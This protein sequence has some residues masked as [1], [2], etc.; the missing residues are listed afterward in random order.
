MDKFVSAF[1]LGKSWHGDSGSLFSQSWNY[2]TNFYNNYSLISY[3][4]ASK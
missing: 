2:L 1:I 3:S 4:K